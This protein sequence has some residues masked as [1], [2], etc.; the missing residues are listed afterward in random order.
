[1]ASTT[2]FATV[3]K[4]AEWGVARLVAT[5]VRADLDEA[6]AELSGVAERVGLVPPSKGP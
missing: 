2:T 4:V 5:C 1:M 3:E 6:K